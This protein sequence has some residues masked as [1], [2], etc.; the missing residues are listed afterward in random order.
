MTFIFLSILLRLGSIASFIY[1]IVELI[2]YY[3][4]KSTE[5]HKNKESKKSIIITTLVIGSIIFS[6]IPYLILKNSSPDTYNF[7]N[8]NFL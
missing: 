5:N 2:K 7:F 1:G 4:Y 6:A 8:F 3:Q